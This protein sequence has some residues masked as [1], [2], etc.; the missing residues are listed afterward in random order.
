MEAVTLRDPNFQPH[1]LMFWNENVTMKAPPTETSFATVDSEIDKLDKNARESAFRQDCL[2]L[3]RDC[4]QL[5]QLYKMDSKHER[6]VKLQKITH[7]K[8][9]NAVG[10]DFIQKYMHLNARHVAG[11]T[12]ELESALDEVG[13]CINWLELSVSGSEC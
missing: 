13:L 1:H 11:R 12:G 3:A 7:L 10:A 4:A 5:A 2:K 6:G 9:Q 8:Q